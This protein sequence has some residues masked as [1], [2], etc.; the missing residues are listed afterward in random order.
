M[1]HSISAYIGT[2]IGG[3]KSPLTPSLIGLTLL[4]QAGVAIGLIFQVLHL[5]EFVDKKDLIFNVILGSTI[6]YE[7]IGPILSRYALV[8]SKEVKL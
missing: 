6:I 4:P 2:K 7:V 3:P 1:S 5:P 8:K